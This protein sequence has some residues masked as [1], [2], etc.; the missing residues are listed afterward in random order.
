[1]ADPAEREDQASASVRVLLVTDGIREGVVAGILRNARALGFEITHAQHLDKALGLVQE[2]S[3]EV[4]LLDLTG[5]A[6]DGAA[7]A[8]ERVQLAAARLPII[9][10][11]EH[12]DEG[13]AV[14]A[15]RLGVQ[16]YI[17]RD[18]ATPRM[19]TRS[20]RYAVERHR[21]LAELQRA[22]QRA[23]F[24]ATHDNL[25]GLANRYSF[26]E[27]L[28]RALAYSARHDR[29][30]AVF[31]LDLDRFKYI[32]DTLGHAVGDELLNEVAD[33]LRAEVRK[34]DMVARVGGDEFIAMIQEL[35]RDQ[36]AALVA[37]KVLDSLS[38]P[39]TLDGREY[40]V[41]ASLGIATFPRDGGDRET[42]I[43][44]ADAAMYQA[45]ALGKNN[46]QFYSQALNAESSKRL[47]LERSLRR[48]VER[49]EFRL[50]YQPII[51]MQTNR[52]TGAEALLR[53]D[54]PDLGA[55]EPGEFIPLAEETGLIRPLGD[56]VLR[57]ACT[58][59]AAW[60]QAGFTHVNISVNISI[61]QIRREALREAIIR[62][63]WDT[64]ID[65]HR[66]RLEITESTLM[67]NSESAVP[68]LEELNGIGIGISLDDFGTGFSSLSYLKRIPVDTVKID[69]SFV[70]DIVVD[71]D[72]AAIVSAILKIAEQLRLR[73]VAEGVE[74][75]EQ[76]SFL[77]S[78]GCDEM[79]G[80][81]FSPP[82]RADEFLELLRKNEAE[83]QD[84]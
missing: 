56:W 45:K 27:Q 12:D 11:A 6:A 33:R 7:A 61:H 65:P 34:S 30:L 38:M 5:A 4:A 29:H 37:S 16:D 20:I 84:S 66:L 64:E 25:T 81:L 69:K 49:S 43:R 24:T 36:S 78:R 26:N 60:Q 13:E 70:N 40:W 80:F 35:D 3:F 79:Q 57:N 44:H 71:P 58:D 9:A 1:M 52:I 14:R 53:W 23:H 48:A 10:V 75:Q 77:A 21:M 62:T 67:V 2:G 68:A 72:D 50:H 17:A 39:Y 8:L 74:T 59:A 47:T 15:L 31:F 32:N 46:Y 22:R 51:D 55:V 83:T 82:V 41:T 28:D 63:L 18:Q 73:V 76:R 19:L 42:L 54:D